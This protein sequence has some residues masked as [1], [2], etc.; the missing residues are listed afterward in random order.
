MIKN[1][2]QLLALQVQA[3]LE[4]SEDVDVDAETIEDI[5]QA[6]IVDREDVDDAETR[7]ETQMN[8]DEDSDGEFEA[9]IQ[10]LDISPLFEGNH[11]G[12]SCFRAILPINL[13]FTS[14]RDL[15]KARNQANAASPQGAWLVFS[16]K[17]SSA[18]L[19]RVSLL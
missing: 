9:S 7:S 15:V 12:F 11:E 18:R 4:A 6:L 2:D 13:C 17:S 3:F 16:H 1:G 10:E 19:I 8:E 5:L 14:G